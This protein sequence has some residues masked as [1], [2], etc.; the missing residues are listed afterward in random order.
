MD[1]T[2][3]ETAEKKV[4]LLPLTNFR[5][6]AYGVGHAANDLFASCWFSYLLVYLIKVRGLDTTY[7]G[8]VMLVG[9]IADGISTPLVGLFSDKTKTKL[10]KRRTWVLIGSCLTF[11]SFIFIFN[12]CFLCDAFSGGCEEGTQRHL[13]L[14]TTYYSLL[15]LPFQFGW[16]SVQINHLALVPELTTDQHKR[17]LLNSIR[18][19]FTIFS[20]VAVFLLTF[21]LLKT[22]GDGGLSPASGQSFQILSYC[23]VGIGALFTIIFLVGTRENKITH[24]KPAGKM[25]TWTKWFKE[26]MFYKVGVIYMCTRLVIN[27]SQVYLPFYLLDEI[28]M[29]KSSIGI[30]PL[31]M[32]GGS[33]LA[34]L[35]LRFI[36]KKLCRTSTY[37]IACPFVLAACVGFYFLQVAPQGTINTSLQDVIYGIVLVLGLGNAVI[38]VTSITMEA[39]MVGDRTESGAFVYGALSLLDKISNGAAVMVVQGLNPCPDPDTPCDDHNYFRYI[40]TFVPGVSVIVAFAFTLLIRIGCCCTFSAYEKEEKRRKQEKQ[41][42]KEKKAMER[43]Q[44]RES[45]KAARGAASSEGRGGESSEGARPIPMLSPGKSLEKVGLLED[46]QMG[47]G[48]CCE[49]PNSFGSI[50][51][52]YMGVERK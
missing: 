33:I 52:G 47:Y 3:T 29:E 8:I 11:T 25:F 16:A 39:D 4:E 34:T 17:L 32:Y 40:M 6:F 44:A 13:Q 27:V 18:F 35:S 7:A 10:G 14:A 43:A 38:L 49:E 48:G 28:S 24:T 37:M 23:C 12:E 46:Q 21:A 19:G 2:L 42:T 26:S 1:A 9:Q 45:R 15:T 36:S 41:A 20:N 31:V 50:N 5:I 30:V 51:G 22:D